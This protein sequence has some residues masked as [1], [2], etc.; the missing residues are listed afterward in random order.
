MKKIFEYT[1]ETGDALIKIREDGNIELIFC[2]DETS[3][4]REMVWPDQENYKIAVQF[5]LMLD[6]FIRNGDA[7][8]EI[9][10]TSP[11]GNIA[12]DL[13]T[14]KEGSIG[15]IGLSAIGDFVESLPEE[16]SEKGSSEQNYPDN[17]LDLM[18]KLKNKEDNENDK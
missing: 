7:L 12:N 11:S 1:C 3:I 14:N 17:V 4:N 9:I 16:E 18:T 2:E 15:T 5:A 8:D 6:S 13:L 10:M